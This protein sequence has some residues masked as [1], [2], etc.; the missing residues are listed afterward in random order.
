MD[1]IEMYTCTTHGAIPIADCYVSHVKVK[2]NKDPNF[3]QR[4]VQCKT[5]CRERAQKRRDN[6]PARAQLSN[7]KYYN[8]NREE[9]I[10]YERKNYLK[11]KDKILVRT[12]LFREKLRKEVLTHYCNG[13]EPF[14][15]CCGESHF[16]FLCLDHK[17]GDGAEHRKEVGS[18]MGA[19]NWARKNNYPD[20]FRV[21]CHNC[22]FCFG[23]WGCCPHAKDKE[24]VK[25][26]TSEEQ[27][28]SS[29]VKKM[30]NS[31]IPS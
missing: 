3:R 18:S 31:N 1:N 11:H 2:K 10:T 28:C 25:Q 30:Q 29:N 16:E 20:R 24:N 4:L 13:K 12:K 15:D 8:K 21:L 14:C 27:L 9:L 26:E 22:N 7:K 6:D 23:A 19:Y 17:Y 5:C